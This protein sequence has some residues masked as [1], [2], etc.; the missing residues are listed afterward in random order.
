MVFNRN[1]ALDYLRGCTLCNGLVIEFHGRMDNGLPWQRVFLFNQSA[2]TAEAF[3][4]IADPRWVLIS[5]TIKAY[6]DGFGYG[7][8]NIRNYYYPIVS[9]STVQHGY[10]F[11]TTTDAILYTGGP[12]D[13]L[14]P[15]EVITN[16]SPSDP[17]T[18]A[19]STMASNR[20]LMRALY[21]HQQGNS[22]NATNDYDEVMNTRR[23]EG[24]AIADSPDL[25]TDGLYA[26]SWRYSTYK[27]MEQ[28]IVAYYMGRSR[29]LTNYLDEMQDPVDGKVMQFCKNNFVTKSGGNT[30]T[31]ALAV[32]ADL[33][34]NPPTSPTPPP[35]PGPSPPPP[36]PSEST[37]DVF[38]IKK[39][40]S[41]NPT[42]M[43]EWYSIPWANGRTRTITD[44][45]CGSDPYDSTLKYRENS[46]SVATID[47]NGVL[48]LSL[49]GRIAMLGTWQ[50]VEATMYIRSPVAMAVSGIS[51]FQPKTE[52][53]CLDCGTGDNNDCF[54]GYVVYIDFSDEAIYFKKEQSHAIG[55]SARTAQ[56]STT[57]NADTWYGIK[58][59]AYT[60]GTSVKLEVWKD[61]TGGVNG[62]TWTKVTEYTDTGSWVVQGNTYAARTGTVRE[63]AIRTDDQG[64]GS[65][66]DYKWVSCREIIPPT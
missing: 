48:R 2:L 9:Q 41:L 36:P 29:I 28:W 21:W 4:R 45:N 16:T 32:I 60:V 35:P 53:Y 65:Y 30:E 27:T 11:L 15:A 33:L 46:G 62:G 52:H 40:Y 63:F 3:R 12:G 19:A 22:T 64:S 44:G 25:Q 57:L 42:T 43:R 18:Q 5:N 49:G 66:F 58:A 26:G 6:F 55:Y 38:G 14:H 10:S 50:N 56:Q 61:N 13:D 8:G 20:V 54:G 59:I 7:G 47:G 37:L 34:W 51:H 1:A 31:T 24:F 39:L 23:P 17:L